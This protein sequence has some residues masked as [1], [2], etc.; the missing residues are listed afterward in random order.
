MY[1]ITKLFFIFIIKIFKQ[2][3]ELSGA[4]QENDQLISAVF[5]SMYKYVAAAS[6]LIHSTFSILWVLGSEWGSFM[7]FKTFVI[8][9]KN[10]AWNM[11]IFILFCCAKEIDSFGK[12]VEFLCFIKL[13]LE[14]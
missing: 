6:T 8:F 3:S 1:W 10:E 5:I 14:L 7:G 12:F 4:N 9:E 13:C 2:L 11:K